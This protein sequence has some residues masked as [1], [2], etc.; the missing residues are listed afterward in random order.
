MYVAGRCDLQPAKESGGCFGV[1][2]GKAVSSHAGLGRGCVDGFDLAGRGGFRAAARDFD[3]ER[4]ATRHDY[5]ALAP[6]I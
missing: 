1:D 3:G 2:D 4:R 5:G 6:C